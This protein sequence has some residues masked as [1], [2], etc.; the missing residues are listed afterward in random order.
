MERKNG[1]ASQKDVVGASKSVTE[2]KAVAPT[3]VFVRLGKNQRVRV[4]V[5]MSNQNLRTLAA[6]QKAK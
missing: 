2:R 1:Q 6:L 5:P 4:E 3:H